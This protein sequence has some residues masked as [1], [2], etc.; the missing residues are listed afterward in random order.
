MSTIA[1]VAAYAAVI[2]ILLGVAMYCSRDDS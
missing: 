1:A 2:V